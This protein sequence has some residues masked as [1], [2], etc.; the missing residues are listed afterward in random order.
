MKVNMQMHANFVEQTDILRKKYY[1]NSKRTD[2]RSSFLCNQI[3]DWFDINDIDVLNI[4]FEEDSKFD[5]YPRTITFREASY[6]KLCDVAN[7][8]N[9]TPAC[10]LRCLISYYLDIEVE[11]APIQSANNTKLKITQIENK[12]K[13]LQDLLNELKSDLNM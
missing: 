13:E 7:V 4:F 5:K 2:Y 12:I 8:I 9:K 3:I 6:K 11:T 10:V 1:P